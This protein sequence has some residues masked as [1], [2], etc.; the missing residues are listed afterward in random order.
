M[1]N[2][3]IQLSSKYRTNDSDSSSNC[4]IEM[5]LILRSGRYRLNYALL[6]NTFYNVNNSNNKLYLQ[7]GADAEIE[8]TLTNGNYSDS[9]FPVLLKALLDTEGSQ[10]YTVTLSPSTNKLSISAIANFGFNFTGRDNNAH[11]LM[12]FANADVAQATSI[13]STN[14]INLSPVH[15]FNLSISGITGID[16]RNLHSTTFVIPIPAGSL[17][18]VNYVSTDGF[19]QIMELHSDKRIV[20][21][22]VRDELHN[23]L[24]LN[25]VDFM[26]ILE[27]L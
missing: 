26:I 17:S 4:K 7:E 3:F 6:P 19:D 16:Q 5:P 8:I 9:T 1:T 13:T 24:D 21:C 25:G 14:M 27:R 11:G 2:K 22:V 20:D 18:Y 12:G 10:S 15:T 23:I